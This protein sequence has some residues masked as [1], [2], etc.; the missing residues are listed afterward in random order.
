MS[1][2]MIWSA[3]AGVVVILEMLTGTFYLLMVA[4]GL[5]AGAVAAWMNMGFAA[6]LLAASVVAGVG[7]LLLYRSRFGKSE[8]ESANRNPDV[9]MDIGQIL[10]VQDWREL[11][12]GVYQGRTSYRGA[13][14]D[15]ELQH[16]A[17]QPGSYKIVEVQGSKLL[18]RPV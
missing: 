4:L 16:A 13:M 1:G 2:W 17:A 10:Q 12:A 15:V 8:Q 7:I 9:N 3:L 6:Q 11:Q 18:V 5:F 14:W